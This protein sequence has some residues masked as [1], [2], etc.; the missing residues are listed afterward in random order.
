MLNDF[1]FNFSVKFCYYEFFYCFKLIKMYL[2]NLDCWASVQAD[3]PEKKQPIMYYENTGEFVEPILYMESS[4]IK[5]KLGYTI[6]LYCDGGFEEYK[7]SDSL[8]AK[9]V[10]NN[11]YEIVTHKNARKNVKL[12]SLTCRVIQRADTFPTQKPCGRN[13]LLHNVGWKINNIYLNSYTMCHNDAE[14]ITFWTKHI[15][16]PATSNP[17]SNL[18]RVGFVKENFFKNIP[19]NDNLK[20]A[21][22]E[23]YFTT[24]LK[25]NEAAKRLINV[26]TNYFLVKGHLLAKTDKVLEPGQVSTFKDGNMRLQFQIGNEGNWLRVEKLYENLLDKLIII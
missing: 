19:L 11:E 2:L 6:N 12:K 9:C 13:G 18:D 1:L 4:F 20:M 25:S 8:D 17:Q 26:K 16:T 14:A 5:V 22:Q 23:K 3:L 24:V 7:G 21:E 15:M 10:K